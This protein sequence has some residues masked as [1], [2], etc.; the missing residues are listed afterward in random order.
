MLVEQLLTFNLVDTGTV[1]GEHDTRGARAVNNGFAGLAAIEAP[2]EG[3]EQG[4]RGDCGRQGGNRSGAAATAAR[5]KAR[6]RAKLG[7]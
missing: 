6:G 3:R 1:G 4:E 5:T 7:G 2:T